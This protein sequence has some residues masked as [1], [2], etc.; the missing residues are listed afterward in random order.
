MNLKTF[1]SSFQEKNLIFQK[2]GLCFLFV[3]LLSTPRSTKTAPPHTH[4][5]TP[6]KPLALGL[7]ECEEWVFK[8]WA[9]ELVGV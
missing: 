6:E 4:T 2:N 9:K 3:T 7:E 8:G 1:P 5:Q